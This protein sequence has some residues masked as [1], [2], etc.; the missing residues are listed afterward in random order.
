MNAKI[1]ENFSLKQII[2]QKRVE[3]EKM[4]KRLEALEDQYANRKNDLDSAMR[5]LKEI[6]QQMMTRNKHETQ[7]NHQIML[8]KDQIRQMEAAKQS[9]EEKIIQLSKQA[10]V[11]A[12][13][14]KPERSGSKAPQ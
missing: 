9:L 10:G 6:Q 7:L 13:I 14:L 5:D 8:Q 3:N 2:D 1:E 12:P 4:K 11:S